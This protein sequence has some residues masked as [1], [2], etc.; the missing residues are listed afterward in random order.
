RRVHRRLRSFN[1]AAKGSGL[2]ARLSLAPAAAVS[3]AATATI[4]AAATTTAAA[5]AA[6]ATPAAKAAFRLRPRFVHDQRATIHLLFVELGDRLLRVVIGC[7][8]DESEA[9]GPARRHVPHHPDRFHFAD[10][11]KQ[12]GK[13][14]LRG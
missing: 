6:S 13:L 7:H 2:P 1:S 14:V 3:T 12:L 8:F 5:A 4:V 9:A 10:P 11:A